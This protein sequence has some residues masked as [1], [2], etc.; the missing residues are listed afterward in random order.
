MITIRILMKIG[1]LLYLC[2][3]IATFSKRGDKAASR[4]TAAGLALNLAVIGL[5]YFKAWPMLPMH[6]GAAA[7]P[8]CTGLI[9]LLRKGGEKDRTRSPF[10]RLMVAA[11]VL[12]SGAAVLFPMDF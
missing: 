12:V 7:M 10:F 1:M 11:T 9:P 2:G 6:L 3:F 5:R 8:F 4:F